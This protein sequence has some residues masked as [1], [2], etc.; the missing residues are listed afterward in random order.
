M[1]KK[2]VIERNVPGV[3]SSSSGDYREIAE[4]SNK[5]LE[6]IGPGIQWNESFI[7]G[8]KIY[9]VYLAEN[10][11]LIREHGRIGGFPVDKVTEVKNIIDPTTA[12]LGDIKSVPKDTETEIYDSIL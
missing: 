3:G 9:C 7:T 5:A 6:Q 8:D 12:T 11:D 2:F 4:K 10:E 1:L